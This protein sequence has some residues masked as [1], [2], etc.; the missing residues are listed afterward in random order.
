MVKPKEVISGSTENKLR[1]LSSRAVDIWN[2]LNAAD[3]KTEV[4]K[5]L[6][7]ASE[8]DKEIHDYIIQENKTWTETYLNLETI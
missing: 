5:I 4:L 1:Q 6:A 8:F 3:Y 2:P 7:D